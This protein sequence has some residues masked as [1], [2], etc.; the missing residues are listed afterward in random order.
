MFPEISIQNA[1]DPSPWW[2]KDENKNFQRGRLIRAF[3]PHV[4][5]IPYTV[6][7]IGRPQAS[8]HDQATVR[9]EPLRISQPPRQASLPVAGMP[10]FSREVRAIYR[11]KK[12]PVLILSEGGAIVPDN[13][14]RGKPKSHTSPTFLVAPYYGSEADGSRAGYNPQFLERV[15]QCEFPQFISDMLPLGVGGESVLRMDHIQPIGRHYQSIE[16]TEHRLS[17]DALEIIDEWITWIMTGMLPEDGL[18][19]SARK[20]FTRAI[21]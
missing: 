3:I 14:T 17:E 18:I 11:A 15:R 5:Q 7:P 8:V 16:F 13:L 20:T 21:S 1:I 12:R 6:I 2:I 10:V 19:D 9:I 4:D